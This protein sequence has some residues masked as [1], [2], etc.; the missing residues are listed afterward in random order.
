MAPTTMVRRGEISMKIE[1]LIGRDLS[2]AFTRWRSLTPVEMTSLFSLW[3]RA[4]NDV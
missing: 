1:H 4:R 3:G 2:T